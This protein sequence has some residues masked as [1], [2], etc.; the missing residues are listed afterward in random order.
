VLALLA[1]LSMTASIRI[2]TSGWIYPHWRG[3][4]YPP[5]LPQRAWLEFYGSHFSTVEVNYSFYRLPS[6]ESF[7]TWA[8]RTPPDFC[9]ALKGS[10]FVTQMKRL[11]DP[12]VHVP[13]FFERAVA[14]GPKLGPVL[15]QLPPQ[16]QRDDD[17]LATFLAALPANHPNAIEF[18]HS[19]WLVEPVYALLNRHGV[20]LCLADRDGQRFPSE[21]L[22]TTTLSYLRFHSGLAGGDYTDAQ[23]RAWTAVIADFRARGASVYAYF[24]NDWDGYAVKN[25][26]ELEQLVS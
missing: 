10:R 25:A 5:D 2:G 26:R 23:L 15:W 3:R 14:L 18:R 19:S 8:A 1:L 21:P 20:A 11:K 7:V 24:N 16:L 6:T 22:L 13:R 12:E 4:F 17:R 9:F